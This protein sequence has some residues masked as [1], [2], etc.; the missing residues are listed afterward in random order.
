MDEETGEIIAVANEGAVVAT[1]AM[2]NDGG[3]ST[4]CVS[5]QPSVGDSALD[6][7]LG[8]DHIDMPPKDVALSA[9]V[10]ASEADERDR[11]RQAVATTFADYALLDDQN[12]PGAWT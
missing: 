7:D 9:H 5:D 8:V 11:Y 6:G 1:G 10:A 12:E 2:V 3:A 4:G